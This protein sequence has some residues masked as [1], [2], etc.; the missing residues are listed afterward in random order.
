MPQDTWI[1]AEAVIA[2][3][4]AL[5]L[6]IEKQLG[7]VILTGAAGIPNFHRRR[8]E[9]VSIDQS[10]LWLYSTALS[11]YR[12]V[13]ARRTTAQG[14]MPLI[15]EVSE[16]LARAATYHAV[17]PSPQ[18]DLSTSIFENLSS[19]FQAVDHNFQRLQQ[20]P[21]EEIGD[22]SMDLI[23]ADLIRV[24]PATATLLSEGNVEI[25]ASLAQCLGM[26]WIS[27]IAGGLDELLHVE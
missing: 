12:H 2:G 24:A 7:D 18:E 25:V 11:L 3:A 23:M 21:E 22:A 10:F 27:A 4:R 13:S 8:E 19:L 16:Q 17:R 5:S 26:L 14:V 6:E 20:L 1:R 9:L 15:R